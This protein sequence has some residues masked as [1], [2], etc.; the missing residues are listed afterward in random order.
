MR[1]LGSAAALQ[2]QK[3]GWATEDPLDCVATSHWEIDRRADESRAGQQLAAVDIGLFADKE[4]K[5]QLT[6]QHPIFLEQ[7]GGM[8][9]M[10]RQRGGRLLIASARR[11]RLLE[12]GIWRR[13]V[14]ICGRHL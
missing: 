7:S 8:A 3:V 2:Y 10:T 4:L 9:R 12:I 13:G 5:R 11:P 14:P 6:A 1:I